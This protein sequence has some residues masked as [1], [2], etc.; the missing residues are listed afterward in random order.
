MIKEHKDII[1]SKFDEIIAN[2]HALITVFELIQQTGLLPDFILAFKKYITTN[3]Q[4]IFTKKL[5]PSESIN[6]IITL[7]ERCKA[8]QTVLDTEALKIPQKQ[9]LENF[10]NGADV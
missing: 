7:V 8:V 6:Q 2:N 9:A 4:L 1:L 10:I 3:A 5:E